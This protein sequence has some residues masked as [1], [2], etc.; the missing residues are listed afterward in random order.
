VERGESFIF[1][2]ANGQPLA[3]VYFDDE[4]RRRSVTKRVSRAMGRSVSQRT[5]PSCRS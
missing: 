5:S 1:N 2:D 4:P 3:Y